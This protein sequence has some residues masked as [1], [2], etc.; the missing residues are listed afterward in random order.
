MINGEY[1]RPDVV[2]RVRTLLF[3][4]KCNLMHQWA[5]NGI[6]NLPLIERILS[7]LTCS[8]SVGRISF[9]CLTA[10]HAI[11]LSPL[12][13]TGRVR[14]DLILRR[15]RLTNFAVEINYYIFWVCVYSSIYPASKAHALYCILLSC[16]PCL[17]VQYFSTLSQTA[18]FRKKRNYP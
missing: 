13:K 18:S 8:C 17:A 10:L 4:Q 14:I 16:T 9:T 6:L 1:E 3:E 7:C 15:V 5:V 2:H 12:K 11:P